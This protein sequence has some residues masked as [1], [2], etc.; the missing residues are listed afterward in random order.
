MYKQ[1]NHPRSSFNK[2]MPR[3]N[4]AP[5][6]PAMMGKSA[7]PYD[8]LSLTLA[9]QRKI[10]RLLVKVLNNDTVT[11]KSEENAA[12]YFTAVK[13]HFESPD[14]SN[15]IRLE[16]LG[17]AVFNVISVANLLT[18]SG[19]A[20]VKKIKTKEKVIPYELENGKM[21]E[22]LT[23]HIKFDLVKAENFESVRASAPQDCPDYRK[24]S[25]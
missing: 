11:I 14:S 5:E 21:L 17:G 4:Q 23:A 12:V 15:I 1:S 2:Q 6:T 19:V 16:G 8:K 25:F 22:K 3:Y 20:T 24:R 18:L 13:R 9:Q 7:A 10:E